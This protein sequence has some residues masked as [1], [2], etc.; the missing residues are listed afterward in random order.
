[1]IYLGYKVVEAADGPAA[2]AQL[3]KRHD[4][5]LMLSDIVMP[6]GIDGFELAKKAIALYQDTAIL[7]TTGFAR[8]R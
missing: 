5:K 7:L 3:E 2:L 6:G 4:I 1:M 8:N